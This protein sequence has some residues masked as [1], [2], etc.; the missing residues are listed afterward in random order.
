MKV[1]S[2]I[3]V[4]GLAA[5]ACGTATLAGNADRPT[6]ADEVVLRVS[7]GGGFVPVEYALGEFPQFS[8]MGD[9]L[10]V[11]QGAQIA[12]YPP[13]ALP[14]MIERTVSADG[15]DAIVQR[16]IE[17]GL[18]G[19]D[20]EYRDD[21]IADAATTTFTLTA[22][23]DTHTTSV[24]ALSE[25]DQDEDRRT[26]A[27][28]QQDLFD[29]ASWLPAEDL[30][31]ESEYRF[32]AMRIHVLTPQANEEFPQEPVDWPLATPLAAFGDETDLGRCGVVEG[33]D[34]DAVLERARTTN[35]LTPWRSAGESYQL[36]FRP[37]LPDE[38]GC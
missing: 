3:V 33:A 36:V 37:L 30:G 28:L 11:T 19:E 17:A 22:N 31:E 14:A 8:L 2:G 9:G 13:P 38:S 5:A 7:T 1:W 20:R 15:I 23:G 6:G 32:D 34:M 35:T 26:L 4:L 27:Q 21:R 10:V 18:T 25:A 24:Y 16:A 12:I 29:L